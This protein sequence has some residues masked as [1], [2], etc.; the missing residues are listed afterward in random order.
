LGNTRKPDTIAGVER[1]VAPLHSIIEERLEFS[2]LSGLSR[3]CKLGECVEESFHVVSGDVCEVQ[4]SIVGAEE[5]E[6]SAATAEMFCAAG[7][8]NGGKEHLAHSLT[9]RNCGL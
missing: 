6:R 2:R 5:G 7:I 4:V 9:V 8:R 3:R 1:G